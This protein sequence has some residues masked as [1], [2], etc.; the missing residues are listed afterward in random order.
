MDCFFLD[1]VA[2]N[3]FIFFPGLAVS[4][5]FHELARPAFSASF[6]FRRYALFSACTFF[7]FAALMSSESVANILSFSGITNSTLGSNGSSTSVLLRLDAPP[8]SFPPAAFAGAVAGSRRMCRMSS[9]SL[10]PY[11]VYVTAYLPSLSIPVSL[12][13]YHSPSPE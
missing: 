6:F 1:V 9:D 10:F 7:F 2:M 13:V 12:A 8:P 4:K 11:S 3:P 5:L